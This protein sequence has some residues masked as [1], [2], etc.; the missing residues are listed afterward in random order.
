MILKFKKEIITII[1][2][3]CMILTISTVSAGDAD[4]Q[5]NSLTAPQSDGKVISGDDLDDWSDDTDDADEGEEDFNGEEDDWDDEDDWDEDDED[6]WEDYDDDDY[7]LSPS[8][9]EVFISGSVYK[10]TTITAKLLDIEDDEDIFGIEDVDIMFMFSNE[11]YEIVTTDEDGI[12]KCQVDLPV[13]SYNVEVY[14]FDWNDYED[15]YDDPESATLDFKI[16]K[17]KASFAASKLT[18]AYK[19]ANYL[20][21]KLVNSNTKKPIRNSKVLV[22]VY[23]GS[24]CE[25]FYGSTDSKGMCKLLSA[26]LSVGT[27]KVVIT[28]L[29][30]NIDVSNFKTSIKITKST[31][32]I[33][34][35]NYKVGSPFPI[36]LHGKGVVIK[37][38]KTKKPL[39]NVKVIFKV[40]T[41]GKNYKKYTLYTDLKG[42]CALFTNKY[43][44]GAHKL[45]AS[46]ADSI[47][48]TA[49]KSTKITIKSG[50]KFTLNGVGNFNVLYSKGTTSISY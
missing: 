43:S 18:A 24:K 21:I 6:D 2:V 41:N 19:S 14:V 49:T 29:D 13:G 22:K 26:T 15:E 42:K 46:T 7:D 27:H 4:S 36:T 35:Y 31:P 28:S 32:V 37:D 12:A 48:K 16:T 38:K 3:I 8:K 47:I 44:L 39:Y 1:L 11:E 23:T 40:F 10:A 20:K 50:E 5:Q 30:D 45:V 25:K 34:V 9:L 33:K 17:A